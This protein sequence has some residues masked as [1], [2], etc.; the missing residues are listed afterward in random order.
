M[1]VDHNDAITELIES[2]NTDNQEITLLVSPTYNQPDNIINCNLGLTSAYFDFSSYEESIKTDPDQTVTFHESLEDAQ[3]DQN[4]ILSV[5]NYYAATTPHQIFVRI[6]NDNCYS[7]TSFLLLV[8]NC[9]PIIYNAVSVNGDGLNDTFHIDGLRDIFVN[10]KLY[11]YNRWGRLVWTGDNS[12][13]DW[14][15]YVKDGVGST[16][17]PDGTYFYVLHLNDP[18]YRDAMTGYLYLTH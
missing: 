8:R 7:V 5:F 1:V 6:E 13:A 15:G 16:Q 12:V 2:N 14:D 3:L 11:I 9:P 4:P 17:A 18:E 10:F